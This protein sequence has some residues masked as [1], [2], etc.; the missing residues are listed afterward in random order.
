MAQAQEHVGAG[1]YERTE[2][3]QGYRNGYR[4]RE[5]KT[6]VGRLSLSIPRLR[7][8]SFSPEIFERM[9]R[10]EQALVLS[11]MEMVVNGVSTRKVNTVVEELCGTEFPK[12]TVSDLCKRLD[13]LV[14][15][16]NER[17]LS[18]QE[19]PFVLVD[20]LV[21]KV[22][23]SKRVRMHSLLVATGVNKEGYRE[24]LGIR[25]GESETESN[26]SELFSWL[27]GRGLTGVDLVVSDCHQGLVSAIERHFTGASWQRCQ[28]HL[29]RNIMDACPKKEWN[30]LHPRI[31]MIFDAPDM[32]TARELLSKT[33]QEFQD[34]APKAVE[35]MEEGFED[36]MAVMALPNG[37][38]K[39]LRTTNGVER[40]NEEI[41]RRERVIRIFPNEASAIRLLGAVLMEKDEEWTT[42]RIYMNMDAY[43]SSQREEEIPVQQ[44][45]A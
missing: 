26:W 17:S 13:P 28:T 45:A 8:G 23:K 10:S 7:D 44:K 9:Q 30:E 3:R 4:S 11:L 6:R 5:L 20:A 42:G 40:L 39:K 36:A 15:A 29:M 18:E 32:D 19:Y 1:H 33:M 12:S 34:R 27:K 31:R 14:E 41:R 43:W 25:L 38:R 35:R 37:Y 16:W 21:I 2:E 24:I 22:R